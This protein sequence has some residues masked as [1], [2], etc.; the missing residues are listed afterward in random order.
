MTPHE[1]QTLAYI[2]NEL[3]PGHDIEFREFNLND[4]PGRQLV[5]HCQMEFDSDDPIYAVFTLG[6][7]SNHVFLTITDGD[8]SQLISI[9]A[10]VESYDASEQPVGYGQTMRM[11]NDYL[12][13]NRRPALLFLRPKA[14]PFLDDFQSCADVGGRHLEFLLVVCLSEDE[15]AHKLT[16]GLDALLDKFA[17]E[18]KDLIAIA[19]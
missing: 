19:A 11:D 18:G 1:Q 6:R 7:H 16:Y 2:V 14:F 12:A 8:P 5:A 15:Y 9:L 4:C 13:K 3:K 17:A 10:G